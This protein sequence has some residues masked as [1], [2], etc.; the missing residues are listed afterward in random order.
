MWNISISLI[1][2]KDVVDSILY[3]MLKS[4]NLQMGD[5]KFI[6]FVCLTAINQKKNMLG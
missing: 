4:K 1:G 3:L 2:N 6:L 5:I